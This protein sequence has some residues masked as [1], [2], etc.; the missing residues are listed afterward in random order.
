MLVHSKCSATG[1][2]E[3]YEA[4]P[5]CNDVPTGEEGESGPKDGGEDE[6]EGKHEEGGEDEPR[7]RWAK[8]AGKKKPKAAMG[9]FGPEESEIVDGAYA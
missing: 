7:P 5:G 2:G 8:Y 6:Y 1:W 3:E 9:Q 4:F